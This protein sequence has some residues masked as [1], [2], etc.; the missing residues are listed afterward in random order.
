MS[1]E[2]KDANEIVDKKQEQEKKDQKL[3]EKPEQVD[4]GA[5]QLATEAAEAAKK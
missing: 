3:L 2:K 4:A 5:K 1:L